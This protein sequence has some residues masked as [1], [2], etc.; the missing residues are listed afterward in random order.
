MGIIRGIITWIIMGIMTWIIVGIS[1]G[2]IMGIILG[3]NT[4]I[5]SEIIA[6]I[7]IRMSWEYLGDIMGICILLGYHGYFLDIK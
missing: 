1:R 5:K 6:G 2:I 7:I 3:I 4:G